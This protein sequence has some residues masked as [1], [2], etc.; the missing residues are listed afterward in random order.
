MESLILT[1]NTVALL[2]LTAYISLF[3]R[4]SKHLTSGVMYGRSADVMVTM[5]FG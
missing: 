5:H 4:C 3:F 2:A 1:A